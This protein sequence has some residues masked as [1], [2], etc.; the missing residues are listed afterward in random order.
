MEVRGNFA[1]VY[2]VFGIEFEI[3]VFDVPFDSVNGNDEFFGNLR[4]ATSSDEQCE[5]T[6][7]LC[8]K[9][10]EQRTLFPLSG[11]IG[12]RGKRLVKGLQNALGIPAPRVLCQGRQKRAPEGRQPL[13]PTNKNGEST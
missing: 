11:G 4:V 1:G 5:H 12:N 9:R 10:F 3:E 13:P 7:L 8:G 2:V 6:P